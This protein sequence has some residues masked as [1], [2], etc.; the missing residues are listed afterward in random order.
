MKGLFDADL[1]GDQVLCALPMHFFGYE[2]VIVRIKCT[3][4]ECTLSTHAKLPVTTISTTALKNSQGLYKLVVC[5]YK[6]IAAKH[7]SCT[8]VHHRDFA[9]PISDARHWGLAK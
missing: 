9:F 4:D 6:A 8:V 5:F 2:D 3:Q 7:S 1:D